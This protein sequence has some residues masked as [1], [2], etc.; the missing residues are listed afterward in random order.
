MSVVLARQSSGKDH[1]RRPC[2]KNEAPAKQ[3][4]IWRKTFTSSRMRTKLRSKLLLKLRRC[5]NSLERDQRS[6]NLWSI[7][8]INAHD[9]QKSKK[10]SDDLD[11]LRRSRNPSVVLTANVEVHTNEDAQ[12]HVRDLNLFVTMQLLEETKTTDIPMS[13]STAKNHG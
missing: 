5:R 9:L 8:S 13:G 7:Q 1:M 3:R 2:T 10:S 6:A 4:G 12:V 11:T